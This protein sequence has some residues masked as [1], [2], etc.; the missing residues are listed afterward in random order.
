M[1]KSVLIGFGGIAQAH[2]SGYSKL[3]K[4]GKIKLVA[5]YDIC[6]ERFEGNIEINLGKAEINENEN[7]KFYT[8]LEEMLAAE[9]PDMVDICIPSYL[10]ADMAIDMLGRG[11]NVMSEKPMSLDSENCA[12]M[13]DAAKKAKGKLMIG[14]CLRFYPQYQF[15]KECIGS[16]K[17]GKVL[18]AFFQRLSA[19]PIWG[20]ENWFMDYSKSGGCI[21]DLHI[22]DIDMVRYLFGEPDAVSC[23]A[24]HSL[25]KY[26]TVQTSL[27]YGDTPVTAVGD[28]TLTQYNFTAGYRVDFEGATVAFENGA[29]KVYPKDG[30]E[31]FSPE[32]DDVD[33]ITAELE[34][35]AGIIESGAENTENPPESAAKTIKLIETMKK[36]ADEGGKIID[37]N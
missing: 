13:L 9:K 25:T 12:R 2:R 1:I 20:W 5:A 24:G 33:G 35:F 6:P 37:F 18:S 16:G 15:L 31:V 32:L 14:Q 11:Y 36:S 3:A 26:D 28:W 34:Y 30:S 4:D 10:H 23:R 8:D 29:V 27:F 21:T 19:P 22:H 7:I 17:Y